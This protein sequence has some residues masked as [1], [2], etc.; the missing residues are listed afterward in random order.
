MTIYFTPGPNDDQSYSI[1][2]KGAKY[3]F[4]K[5]DEIWNTPDDLADYLMKMHPHLF[6]KVYKGN[7]GDHRNFGDRENLQGRPKGVGKYEKY[8]VVFDKK[9][10]PTHPF[11][12]ANQKF[13]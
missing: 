2:W 12:K 11:V 1:L 9:E 10:E 13:K 7:K 4:F 5:S 3:K 6:S 8:E